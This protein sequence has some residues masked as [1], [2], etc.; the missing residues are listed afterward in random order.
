MKYRTDC[1]HLQD[2][3]FFH[4]RTSYKFVSSNTAKLLPG[5][6]QNIKK[7]S[8]NMEVLDEHVHVRRLVSVVKM[9]TVLEECTKVEHRSVVR[10]FCGQKVSMQRIL[11]KKYFTFT[12]GSFCCVK[13]FTAG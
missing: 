8:I 4:V 5:L 3:W 2:N 1:S 13:R 7:G 12:L 6:E 11:I 10:F 9:A